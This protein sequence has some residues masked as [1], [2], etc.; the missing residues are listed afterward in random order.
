MESLYGN[1][2]SEFKLPKLTATNNIFS[3]FLNI[4]CISIN[5]N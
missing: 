5:K 1:E 2:S 3:W 4:N